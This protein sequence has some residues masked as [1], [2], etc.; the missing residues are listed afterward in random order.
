[1]S[2]CDLSAFPSEIMI[3]EVLT[4]ASGTLCVCVCVCV[5]AHMHSYSQTSKNSLIHSISGKLQIKGMKL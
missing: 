5:C 3:S 1:M 2:V 4:V